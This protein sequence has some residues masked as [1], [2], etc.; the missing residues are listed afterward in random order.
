MPFT[1][2][3]TLAVT[4][5]F[6]WGRGRLPLTALLLGSMVPDLPLFI[7]LGV[8]YSETHC[9]LGVLTHCLPLAAPAYLVFHFFLKKPIYQLCPD[10]MRRK[11]GFCLRPPKLHSISELSLILCAL[12]SGA[13]T[14]VVW[15]AFSHKGAWG[16][17]RFSILSEGVVIA[18]RFIPG[19][20]LIQYGSSLIGLPIL[21]YLAWRWLCSL[22]DAPVSPAP[23]AA[24]QRFWIIF[25]VA[26]ASL[27]GALH[28]NWP[29]TSYKSVVQFVISCMT[30]SFSGIVLLCAIYHANCLGR[31]N[32]ENEPSVSSSAICR[33]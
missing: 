32:S 4:P 12:C 19:Y 18:G 2:T 6:K 23:L 5:L 8:S 17:E 24:S 7:D 25:S 10:F 28:L 13:L 9:L 22:P 1:V 31:P 29:P 27:L 30:I 3:H 26:L 21:R 20:K 11:L 16:V 33:R 14:H 15:D